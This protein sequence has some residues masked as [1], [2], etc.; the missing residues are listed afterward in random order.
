[1]IHGDGEVREHE[2]L[3]ALHTGI[4]RTFDQD[5]AMALRVL[6]DIALRAAS[7]AVNDPTTAVQALDEIDNLLRRIVTRD[8]AVDTVNGA[9]GRPR[10]R[11]RLLSWDDYVATALDEIVATAGSSWAIHWRVD[12]MLD[13]LMA[14]AP[15]DRVP[16]LRARVRRT[17]PLVG[18]ASMGLDDDTGH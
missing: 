3:G 16:A 14:I 2:L 13:E 8:L 7:P 9:D 12:L 11:L 15:A 18:Q 10:L 6:A 17:R 4:E 1:L 5:P